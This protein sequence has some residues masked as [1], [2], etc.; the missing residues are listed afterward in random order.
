MKISLMKRVRIFGRKEKRI[1][2]YVGPCEILHRVVEVAYELALPTKIDFI[3]VVF[4][5]SMFKKCLGDL[6]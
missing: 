2:R 6:A 3:H 1:L 5:V 4:H